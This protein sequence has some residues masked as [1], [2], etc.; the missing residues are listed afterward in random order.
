MAEKLASLRKK[1]GGNISETVLWTNSAVTSNF[2]AQTVTLSGNLTDYDYIKIKYNAS[3]TDTSS[4]EV[5]MP[6]SLF[7]YAVQG[8]SQAP[9]L[10]LGSYNGANLPSRSAFYADTNKVK[11][12]AG[13]YQG[14][15]SERNN[16]SIP[17]QI[18]GLK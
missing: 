12:L 8:S 9:V 13:Y 16:W 7:I 2:T 10:V 14:A 15:T 4:Y 11:F 17:T 3:T 6:M 1:G 18:I 5:I